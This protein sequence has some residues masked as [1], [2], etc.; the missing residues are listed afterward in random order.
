MSER[1]RALLGL[2]LVGCELGSS[3]RGAEDDRARGIG[4]HALA[5]PMDHEEP[6]ARKHDLR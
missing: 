3:L 2:G 5:V 6:S 1:S 4:E